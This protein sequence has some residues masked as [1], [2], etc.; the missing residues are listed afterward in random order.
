MSNLEAR[1]EAIKLAR[2]LA[3]APESLAFVEAQPPAASRAFREALTEALFNQHRPG[4]QRLAGLSKLLP[5]A[6]TAKLSEH[7]LGATVSGRVAGEMEPGRAVD[8]AKH[9]STGFLADLTVQLDPKRASAVVA[10]MPSEI[11]VKTALELVKREDYITMGRF[12]DVLSEATLAAVIAAIPS[13]EALLRSGFF[14]E[15]KSRLAMLAGLLP[16]S[17]LV[18]TLRVAH[19]QQL[20]PEALALI[21]HVGETHQGRYG[22]LLAAEPVALIESLLATV[23]AQNLWPELL[24]PF[25]QMQPKNQKKLAGLLAKPE[26]RRE[27]EQAARASG[28]WQML[29]P[30]FG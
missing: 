16:E 3:A 8:I 15:N 13:D 6:I 5:A 22:D 26:W 23:S 7:A 20:W 10:K 19:Q 29:K 2:L 17:R 4:F 9:L 27:I 11:V 24:V 14:V 30:L 1:A 18:G 28:N 12:V 21:A 25:V